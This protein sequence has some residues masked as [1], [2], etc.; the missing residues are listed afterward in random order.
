[1]KKLQT[2]KRLIEWDVKTVQ[3]W[4]GVEKEYYGFV[5]FNQTRIG[6][7]Q[8]VDVINLCCQSIT[9]SVQKRG[10]SMSCCQSCLEPTYNLGHVTDKSIQLVE[11]EIETKLKIFRHQLKGINSLNLSM[12]HHMID[13]AGLMKTKTVIDKIKGR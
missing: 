9:M 3:T 5:T 2:I 13:I 11:S 10:L 8:V 7:I 12:A 1:M 6:N 4:Q